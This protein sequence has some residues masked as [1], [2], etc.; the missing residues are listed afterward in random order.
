MP[1]FN[2]MVSKY[3][4]FEGLR[5]PLQVPQHWFHGKGRLAGVEDGVA[6]EPDARRAGRDCGAAR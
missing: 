3:V 5:E 2:R 4:V 1:G 6:Q